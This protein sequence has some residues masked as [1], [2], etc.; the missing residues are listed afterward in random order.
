MIGEGKR[1]SLGLFFFAHSFSN[2]FCSC[3]RLS[4]ACLPARSN[5]G[6]PGR[7]SIVRVNSSGATYPIPARDVV[8]SIK[9]LLS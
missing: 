3:I 6:V 5:T 9:H 4:N 2:A 8:N 7:N 1:T